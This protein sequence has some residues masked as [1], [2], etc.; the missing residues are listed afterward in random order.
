MSIAPLT[1][2]SAVLFFGCAAGHAQRKTDMVSPEGYAV[3]HI[4][5]IALVLLSGRLHG[6]KM[7]LWRLL[8]LPYLWTAFLYFWQRL[9]KNRHRW[10]VFNLPVGPPDIFLLLAMLVPNFL[11]KQFFLVCIAAIS[12]LRD[13]DGIAASGFLSLGIAG[14]SEA[15]AAKMTILLGLLGRYCFRPSRL[16]FLLGLPCAYL[17]SFPKWYRDEFVVRSTWDSSYLR[18]FLLRWIPAL[19]KPPFDASLR[20]KKEDVAY[21]WGSEKRWVNVCLNTNLG[22]TF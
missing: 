2:Q 4:F 11:L 20:F 13:R 12:W 8:K 15:S 7:L 17:F 3:W 6:S 21:D 16:Q 18:R 9:G 19:Q 5:T 14:A 1:K 10:V 22:L